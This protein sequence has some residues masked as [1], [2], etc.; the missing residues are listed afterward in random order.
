MKIPGTC[1]GL[2]YLSEILGK[3]G[4]RSWG[5]HDFFF[6]K[7]SEQTGRSF[8]MVQKN[9]RVTRGKGWDPN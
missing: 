8:V 9:V 3:W 2:K 1:T 6:G 5:G 7:K 4:K